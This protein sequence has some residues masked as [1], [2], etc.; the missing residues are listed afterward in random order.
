MLVVH[1]GLCTF[2]YLTNEPALYRKRLAIEPGGHDCGGALYFLGLIGCWRGWQAFGLR[3]R[4]ALSL[5]LKEM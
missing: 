3:I 5:R 4:R 1:I 2:Q